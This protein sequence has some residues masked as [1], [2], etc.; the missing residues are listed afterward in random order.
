MSDQEPKRS[1]HSQYSISFSQIGEM[2]NNVTEGIIGVNVYGSCTFINPRALEFFDLDNPAQMIGSPL[3]EHLS[4][5]KN[6]TQASTLGYLYELKNKASADRQGHIMTANGKI[7]EVRS[8]QKPLTND[9]VY[10]GSIIGFELVEATS[11][12]KEVVPSF[13]N[14]NERYKLLLESTQAVVWEFDLDSNHFTFMSPQAETLFGYPI[15]LWYSAGFWEEKIH[16]LD[17]EKAISMCRTSSMSQ[18]E[19]DLEYRMI[20]ADGELIYIKDYVSVIKKGERATALRGI[21]V[22]VTEQRKNEDQIKLSSIV[23]E[24]TD[25]V[26]ITNRD[27]EIIQVNAAFTRITG[28]KQEEVIGKNPSIVSSG[29]Q[30][31]SFY[32]QMWDDINNNHHWQGEIWNKRKSGEIYPEWLTI[33]PVF[34]DDNQVCN[35]VGIFSDISDKKKIEKEIEFKNS[36][37]SL[38]KLPNRTMLYKELKDAIS[39]HEK[40]GYEGV[41]LFLDL[42]EFKLINDSMGHK[43]GDLLLIQAAKRLTSCISHGDILARIGGDEFA[44]LFPAISHSREQSNRYIESTSNK[45]KEV[46]SNSFTINNRQI[47][48]SCS[49]GYS[50]F[51]ANSSRASDILR[52]ADTAMFKAKEAGKNQMRAF[53]P[54]M[55]QEIERH[56]LIHNELSVA[57][58]QNDLSIYFQPLYDKHRKIITAEA[59]LRWHHKDL[60][61]I[62]PSEFIPIAE[63]TG[64]IIP[65]GNFVIQSVCEYISQWKESDNFSLNRI[66]I[67][68]SCQQF[69][70]DS[71]FSNIKETL[72]KFNISPSY[73][74]L[75]ITEEVMAGDIEKI[76]DTFM[77]LKSIGIHFSLD[78][79]GTGYSS[80]RYIKRLPID[81]LKIDQSFINDIPYDKSDCI[82]VNTIM[83]MARQMNLTVTAEGIETEEQRDFLH[84]LDCDHYQGYLFSKPLSKPQFE[85]LIFH[86]S[87]I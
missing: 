84:N 23:F 42:D 85:K 43:Y 24:S 76:I 71:F 58:K 25:A 57:I 55:H 65:L 54:S 11:T 70:E 15:R 82:M 66:D 4:F 35:Y 60:G 21:F 74:G 51:P 69:E 20:K 77:R 7:K 48:I 81:T 52:Q 36:H 63:Q 50:I 56:L 45:I 39:Q 10:S 28:Y 64:L 31:A 16:Q 18:L 62:T 83:A 40:S 33:T 79:F 78:D 38:T 17:R 8:W 13:L 3:L 87:E 61:N 46:F 47:H 6:F 41:L 5:N 37:D 22:D 72:E 30:D 68:V 26:V 67:N 86:K 2:F 32:K 14:G 44:I 75:E 27:K 34:D 1:R 73:L 12:E 29:K 49:I 53:M 59:L 19:Y 80:L 9:G